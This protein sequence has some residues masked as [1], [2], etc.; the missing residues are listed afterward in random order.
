M[1]V[2]KRPSRGRL[3]LLVGA[4]VLVCATFAG[5]ALHYYSALVALS[6]L[7]LVLGTIGFLASRHPPTPPVP[8]DKELSH[9]VERLATEVRDVWRREVEILGLADPEPMP[10]KWTNTSKKVSDHAQNIGLKRLSFF[11]DGSHIPQLVNRFK[12]LPK[13]RLVVLGDPGCGKSTLAVQMLS[14]LLKSRHQDEPVPVLLNVA[15]WNVA[16]DE[17]FSGWLHRRLDSGFPFLRAISPTIV[18]KLISERLV[19]PIL[20]GLDEVHPQYQPKILQALKE[21]MSGDDPLIV[22]CRTSD[23]ISLVENA[24]VVRAA[25]V[26]EAQRIPGN[27]VADFVAKCIAPGK[28]F[29]WERLLEEIRTT[30]LFGD[31]AVTPLVLWLFRMVYIEGNGDP[32]HLLDRN[33]F[34]SSVEVKR[35]LFRQLIPSVIANRRPTTRAKDAS[36]P[37]RRWDAQSCSRWLGHL[38]VGLNGRQDLKW[39]DLP[40]T[41]KVLRLTLGSALAA[42]TA[43]STFMVC[44]SL[45]SAWVALSIAMILGLISFTAVSK[46]VSKENDPHCANLKFQGRVIFLLKN[47]LVWSMPGLCLLLFFYAIFPAVSDW[48]K[49]VVSIVIS[50][51][52]VVGISRWVV[53]PDGATHSRR[54]TSTYRESRN[55][56]VLTILGIVAIIGPLFLLG[57][58]D[59]Q[60][61]WQKANL[62]GAA[63]VVFSFF[64]TVMVLCVTFVW[65]VLNELAWGHYHLVSFWLWVTKSSPLNLIY[66]LEDAN[67]LGLLRT[68]G[69]AYQFRHTD[70]RD[71]LVSQYSSSDVRRSVVLEP[72]AV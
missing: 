71:Y 58:N 64:L 70:L 25:L 8:G 61:V 30:S 13:R 15:G 16:V 45:W 46:S 40:G 18:E 54:P 33:R 5:V 14:E 56:A 23:F 41:H 21:S 1:T 35:E 39:W 69:A 9:A 10:I 22:T 36:R 57:Y 63:L 6:I 7:T 49:Y 42:A 62:S 52:L 20:D 55:I 24:D 32:T 38:A 72:S 60:A 3:F 51:G 19:L 2:G 4:L 59:L 34:P 68:A 50:T 29:E 48:S 12:E 43:F 31:D 26:I 17:E 67:R 66:F 44:V 11:V 65:V 28:V 27:E 53:E 37:R 47:V